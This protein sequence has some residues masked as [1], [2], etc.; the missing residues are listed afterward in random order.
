MNE[1]RVDIHYNLLPMV[2]CLLKLKKNSNNATL[3][4]YS[5]YITFDFVDRSFFWSTIKKQQLLLL[6]KVLLL[7]PVKLPFLLLF[8]LLLFLFLLVKTLFC[9]FC[10]F[11]LQR[12]Q[13]PTTAA[14]I[15]S[16]SPID[17]M[18]WLFFFCEGTEPYSVLLLLLLKVQTVTL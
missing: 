1:K 6:V 2:N 18:H 10:D 8:L 15:G 5:F 17:H 11:V 12:H 4:K 3:E 16:P 9:C 13:Y 7:L 14:E